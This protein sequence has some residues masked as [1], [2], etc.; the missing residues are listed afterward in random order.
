MAGTVAKINTMMESVDRMARLP[1]GRALGNALPYTV[2]NAALDGPDEESVRDVNELVI[3]A[4]QK[5][6][7][8]GE[9]ATDILGAVRV[10]GPAWDAQRP[11]YEELKAKVAKA[12]A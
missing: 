2:G 8:T 4:Q 3:Q 12:E 5:G 7:A 11:R 1:K 9:E 6:L 10:G